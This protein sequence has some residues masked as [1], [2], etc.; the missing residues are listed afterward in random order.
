MLHDFVFRLAHGSSPQPPLSVDHIDGN[1]RNNTASN[2]RPATQRLQ[3]LNQRSRTDRGLPRGVTRKSDRY[4]SRPYAAKIADQGRR[5]H[6]GYFATPE[7]AAAVYAS[8]L[9]D[10]IAKEEAKSWELFRNQKEGDR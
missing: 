2:L 3:G 9:A 5:K 8:A 6:L 7:E 1:T 4:R 10:E